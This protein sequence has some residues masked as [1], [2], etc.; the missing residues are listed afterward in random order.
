[1]AFSGT[2]RCPSDR[3]GKTSLYRS[4]ADKL[5]VWGIRTE[6]IRAGPRKGDVSMPIT[7][8]PTIYQ[9]RVDLL[10]SCPLIWRRIQVSPEIMLPQL[11][12]VLQTVIGWENYHLHEFRSGE[13]VYAEPDPE[14]HHFGRDVADERRVRLK[15]LLPAVG[16]SCKYLYDFGADWEHELTLESTLPMRPLKRYPICVAGERSAPPEDAGGMEGYERYLKALFD[17]EHPDHGAMLEWRGRFDPR[18]FSLASVNRKLKEEFPL[19]SRG[20]KRPAT[21]SSF[22]PTPSLPGSFQEEFN[23]IVSSAI[24]TGR[25]PQP[26]RKPAGPE[27]QIPVLLSARDRELIV[28]HSLADTNLTDRLRLDPEMNRSQLFY[29]TFSEL[30]ELMAHVTVRAHHANRE[31]Q[32]EWDELA[33]RVAAV[34]DGYFHEATNIP[35]V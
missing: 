15:T 11:H 7:K 4:V 14:D 22:P 26:K 1:L 31:M 16:A 32:I 18:H 23:R 5:A 6:A 8:K 2:H 9:I 20:L 17:V 21:I 33:E 25:L 29:F 10:E 19:R 24:H 30:D 34:L 35:G 12:R 28:Q 3:A 13:K 27:Y